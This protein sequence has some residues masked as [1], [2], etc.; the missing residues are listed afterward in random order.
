MTEAIPKE[1]DAQ[2]AKFVR[3]PWREDSTLI[4][5][6]I[7]SLTAVRIVVGLLPDDDAEID[8]GQLGGIQTVG[9]F[10]RWLRDLLPEQARAGA[11]R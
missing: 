11:I 6:G 4:E 1:I 2:L 9:Q 8:A 5:V 7:D 10:R 3:V